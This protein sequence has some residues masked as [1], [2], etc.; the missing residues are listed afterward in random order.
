MV[1]GQTD[2]FGSFLAHFWDVANLSQ[3]FCGHSWDAVGMS[4]EYP[5]NV[6]L[7]TKRR[8]FAAI[9]DVHFDEIYVCGCDDVQTQVMLRWCDKRFELIS[10]SHTQ[11]TI[12]ARARDLLDT[13]TEF[14]KTLD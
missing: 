3:I 12:K 7:C 10:K 1:L 4:L 9:R 13:E 6:L 14:R 8:I 11:N 5:Q 2:M